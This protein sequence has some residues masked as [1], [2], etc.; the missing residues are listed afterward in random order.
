MLTHAVRQQDPFGEHLSLYKGRIMDLIV[1]APTVPNVPNAQH[2]TRSHSF[3][4]LLTPSE[5]N[6]LN[7]LS[8]KYGLSK[9]AFTRFG[10]NGL[11]EKAQQNLSNTQDVPVATDAFWSS[12]RGKKS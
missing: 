7:I 9:G 11:M 6:L 12:F 8:K 3:M 10:L 5:N 2:E 1:D 4:V